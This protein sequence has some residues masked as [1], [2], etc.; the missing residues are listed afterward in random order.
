MQRASATTATGRVL[1]LIDDGGGAPPTLL[2]PGNISRRA[3]V[4]SFARN[5]ARANAQSAV[6]SSDDARWIF[7]QRV[8]DSLDGGR[9]AILA[10]DL[11]RDLVCRAVRSGLRPFDA[12]LVIAI[13]QDE[14]RSG[15]PGPAPS[16][17]ALPGT[18]RLVRQA[19]RPVTRRTVLAALGITL[20]LAAGIAGILISWICG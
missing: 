18:L 2:H 20:L 10:P 17:S 15:Q 5:V 7:A 13:V 9:A 8:R 6:I 14:V 11:R 4:E 1:R 12:N 19:D 16:R 3:A